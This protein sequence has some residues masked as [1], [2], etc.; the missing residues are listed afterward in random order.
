[1]LAVFGVA[2]AFFGPSSASLIAN[3]VPAEDFANAVAWNTSGWQ[4]ASIAGPAAGGLLYGLSAEAA[5]GTAAAM[6]AASATLVF[7][8]P[9]PAQR[10]PADKPTL[11]ELFAGEGVPDAGRSVVAGGEGA[12]AVGAEH[13][14]PYR[15][16]VPENGSSR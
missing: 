12:E 15:V 13:G 11:G 8:I 4:V 7:S 3:L 16:G 1:M 2:R 10:G 6:T 5:Y 14:A 9:R